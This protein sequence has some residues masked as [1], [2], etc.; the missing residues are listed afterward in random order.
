[1]L[2]EHFLRSGFY[3]TA[4]KLAQSSDITELTNISLFLVAKEVEEALIKR[5]TTKCLSWCSDNK[6]KMRKMKSSLEFKIRLQEFIELAK[7]GYKMEAV[8]HARAHLANCEKHQ[9]KEVQQAMA[10]LAFP[11]GT[12]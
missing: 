1:M 9:L 10:L 11:P 7:N 5:N 6:S 8:A 2:V 4:I 3:N 12:Y